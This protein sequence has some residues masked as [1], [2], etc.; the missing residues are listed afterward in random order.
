MRLCLIAQP[1][2]ASTSLMHAIADVTGM[3]AQQCFSYGMHSRTVKRVVN[4]GNQV[5]EKL[6][7][8]VRL[9]DIKTMKLRDRFPAMNYPCMAMFHS[10]IADLYPNNFDL[11]STFKSDIHK[12]HFPPTRNN[13]EALDG[14]PKVIILRPPRETIE[15]YRRVPSLSIVLR[16]LLDD[17][18]FCQELEYELMAWQSGWNA[19]SH[20]ENSV[21]VFSKD[22]ILTYP[23]DVINKILFAIGH[24]ENKVANSYQLPEKRVYR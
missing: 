10:D 2:T 18:L 8:P 16:Q 11:K 14:V 20:K 9:C 6:K 5:L 13:I 23:S 3:S 24:G 1:K 19:V 22:E 17:D 15:S 12:Q 7:S 21:L 4:K